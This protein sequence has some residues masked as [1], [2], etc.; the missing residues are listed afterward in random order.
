MQNPRDSR[1][2]VIG[3]AGGSASGK[4]TFAKR[5]AHEAGQSRA[6]VVAMDRFYLSKAD[7]LERG[8]DNY[9]HP[10][11]IDFSLLQDVMQTLRAG[12]SASV[13]IYDFANHDRT[14][15]E[16]V[17]ASQCVILEGILALWDAKI[18]SLIN[19]AVY[20]EVADD[21][22][23]DRRLKRDMRERGRDRQSIESQWNG[24]VI[25]MHTQYVARTKSYA[26]HVIDG[27]CSFDT[28]AQ[29][30]WKSLHANPHRSNPSNETCD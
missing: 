16:T 17:L 30:L 7:R 25:P 23:L 2:F 27:D 9:D 28:S 6:T 4:T 12:K 18:R 11:A 21:V 3:I 22:R 15:F 29:L 20:I 8:L 14:G 1:P 19:F 5:V 10:S 13:P 24:S 26:D